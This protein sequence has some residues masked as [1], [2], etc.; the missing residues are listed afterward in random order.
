VPALDTGGSGLVFPADGSSLWV[1][2]VVAMVITGIAV[3]WAGRKPLLE[4]LA[5]RRED[6]AVAG[7][8]IP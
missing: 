1:S 3:V 8:R 7:G 2:L 6:A 4:Y 5:G